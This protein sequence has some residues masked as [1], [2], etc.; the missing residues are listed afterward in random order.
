MAKYGYDLEMLVKA[1]WLGTGAMV[2]NDGSVKNEEVFWKEFGKAL[3]KDARADEPKF[4]EFY[5]NEFDMV[6]SSCGYDEN[7]R[8]LIDEVKSMGYRVILATNPI[9]PAIAT[10]KRIEWVG[11]TPKDFELYTTYEKIGYCKPNPKYYQE[12]LNQTGLKPE[13]CLMVGNDV[14]E[15]MVAETLGMKVFLL[16]DCIINKE[17]KDISHYPN[18]G[19]HEA[20]EYIKSL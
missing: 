15:D 10:E 5:E 3:N 13:E 18:G 11:L 7:A 9:F 14:T 12:I 17:N 1:V 19:F 4:Q 20:M 16:T 2:K 8:K 6:K